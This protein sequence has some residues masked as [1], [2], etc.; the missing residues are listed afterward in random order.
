MHAR[1]LFIDVWDSFSLLEFLQPLHNCY[2]LALNLSET[3]T[4]CSGYY[5]LHFIVQ[6]TLRKRQGNH[7]A[8]FVHPLPHGNLV[9][10]LVS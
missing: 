9:L 7:G 6:Q 10:P 2:L 5:T 4:V 1:G 8:C 3:S